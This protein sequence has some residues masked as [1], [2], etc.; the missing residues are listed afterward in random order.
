[1]KLPTC[2][3]LEYHFDAVVLSLPKHLVAVRR[4]FQAEAM[5]NDERRVD[6]PLF[7]I[8]TGAS[9]NICGREPAPF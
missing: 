3:W 8:F 5:G 2:L 1:M 9:G 4:V 7:D 6:D